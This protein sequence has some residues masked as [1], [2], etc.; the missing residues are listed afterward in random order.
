VDISEDQSTFYYS[1]EGTT[2]D[3]IDIVV[4]SGGSVDTSLSLTG[5]DNY[6]ITSDDDSGRD[7]DPEISHLV[8]TSDGTYTIALG[9]YSQG[10]TGTVTLTLMRAPLRSLDD[11]PQEVRLNEKVTQDVLTFTAKAGDNYQLLLTVRDGTASP[12]VTVT[13]DGVTLTTGSSSTATALAVGF[14]APEDGPVT[15]QITDYS[16]T[17]VIMDVR[18][19]MAE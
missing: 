17:K 9:A 10:D 2:G 16:Y 11:G 15:V 5:P 4:D 19:E 13:Q 1:F 7:F 12:S 3:V 14:I 6:Q 8:L 18:V